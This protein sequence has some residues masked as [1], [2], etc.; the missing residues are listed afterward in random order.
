[1][2]LTDTRRAST[3]L[4]IPRPTK[5]LIAPIFVVVFCF[6]ALCAYALI[7]ARRATLERAADVANSL[8]AAV[9]A[10][11]SRNIETVDLALQ[12]VVDNLKLPEIDRVDPQIRQL[13]LFDR[14]AAARNLGRLVVLD[15]AGNVRLDAKTL[16]P[17]PLN[18]ADRDYF[19]VHKDS[20]A[21]GMFIS[22]P[23]ISRASGYWI[24]AVSRRLLHPDG[25]FAG[26]A[27]ATLQLSYFEKLFKNILLGPDGSITLSRL[28]G[29]VLM[30]WPFKEEYLGLDLSRAKLYEQLAHSRSGS[31]ETYSATDGLHRLVVYSQIEDIPLVVGVGQST[32]DIYTQ[33]N[34]YAFGIVFMIALLCAMTSLLAIYL[35]HDL[36]RRKDAE[37]K[38]AF[39]AATDV[40]T[41]L[42]NRR[43][44]NEILGREW[45]RG[46]RDKLPLVL[47]MLDADQF[48]AYNDTHG[49]QAGDLMLKAVGAAIG[50]RPRTRRGRRRPLRRGRIRSSSACNNDRWRRAGR[51]KN[52]SGLRRALRARAYRHLRTEYRRR[53]RDAQ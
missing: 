48:K 18:L 16:N 26:V 7:D 38:L 12:G 41:G 3:V 34:E 24:I 45:Q 32:A 20:A 29:I 51:G 49:Y 36:G 10:D 46:Q 31:F 23:T 22:R 52:P 28:D 9:S 19:Q 11:I 40:L 21:I 5:R 2:P 6:C 39:F 35:M 30:R 14:S 42:S 53:L 8:V 25:S 50:Q 47:M 27:V 37:A 17:P 33:W 4:T 15:E 44:F 1:M 43:H 13:I